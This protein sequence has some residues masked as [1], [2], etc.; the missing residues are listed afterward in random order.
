MAKFQALIM[1][2]DDPGDDAP[3]KGDIV[4]VAPLTHEWGKRETLPRRRVVILD[5]TDYYDIKNLMLPITGGEMASFP[6]ALQTDIR[7]LIEYARNRKEQVI[8]YRRYRINADN[9]VEDKTNGNKRVN[10]NG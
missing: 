5:D 1:A 8:K 10:K 7:Q 2:V 4:T 6:A 3:K 9:Q